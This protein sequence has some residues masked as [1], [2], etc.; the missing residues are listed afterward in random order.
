MKPNR[1]V[2]ELPCIELVIAERNHKGEPTGKKYG[3]VFEGVNCGEK[4]AAWYDKQRGHNIDW[5][6]EQAQKREGKN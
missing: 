2:E 4:A 3:R 6:I 5:E 1:K